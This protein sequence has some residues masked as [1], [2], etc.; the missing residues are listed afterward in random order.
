VDSRIERNVALGMDPESARREA[1]HRFGDVGAVRG[2]L[3]DHDA[4]RARAEDRRELLGD[5]M[6]DVRFGMRSLRRAPGFAVAAVLTLALGIGA[7]AAIF[8]VV[9]AIVLRPLPYERP[10]ELVSLGSGSAGE[11]LALR[12]RLR[13]ISPLA[14]YSTEM[15]PFDDGQSAQRLE[16]AAISTNLLP[17]LG[18]SP[19]LGRGF[20]DDEGRA[21]GAAVLVLSHGLWQR[22]FGGSEAAIGS[23]VRVDG[24]PH[25]IIGVMD[26]D[27]AFPSAATGFWTPYR[28]DTGNLPSTWAFGG[29]Q[30]VARLAP[31]AT[32][33]QAQRDL[34]VTWP[35]LRTENPMWDPG[36][37][38]R[39]DA[40][41]TPLGDEQAGDAAR[42]AWLLLGCVLLVL[43]IGCVNIANLLLARGT[44]RGP[45]LAVRTALGGGR[46][47]L[48]RQLVTESLLLSL[49]GSALGLVLAAAGVRWLVAALPA[50][51]PRVH[52]IGINGTVLAF[53]ASIAIA[54]GL[55][56]GIVPALRATRMA[57][58]AASQGGTRSTAG[59]GQHRL[60]GLLVV[61]EMALAVVLV[62]GASLLVRSFQAI[63]AVE[64]GF[65]TEQIVAARLTPPAGEY[66]DAARVS[67]LYAA[68]LERLGATP[69]VHA[70][71]AVD[72]LPIAQ[73]VYGMA[74]RVEGQ[75]EDLRR[76]LPGI[77]HV[78][79]VTPSYFTT[80][81]IPVLRGRG[82][83][84]ADREDQPPVVIVSESLAREFWPDDD[85]IGRRLGYPW[86]SPW[87]TIVGVVPDTRQ[88]SLL[89]PLAPTLYVPWRQ[90]PHTSGSEM[91]IVARS[92]L[93]ATAAAGAIRGIVREIDRAVPVSDMRTME[94][95]IANSLDRTRFTAVLVGTFAL[96]ALLLG[97]IGIYGVMSYLVSQR[98]QEL[99]VRLALGASQ[100][101]VLGFV[102]WR[103]IGLAA[104]GAVIGVAGA[105]VSTRW[106]RSLLYEVSATDAATFTLVP[107]LFLL[108]AAVATYAPARRA[109]AVDPVRALR[110]D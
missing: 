98:S 39:R 94:A 110:A 32:I 2:T 1:L 105:M 30:F 99:G 102:L 27:F 26:A 75:S 11:Y 15:H 48:V 95:V 70:V 62:I 97:S 52:E 92:S 79:Q 5:L 57:A 45:E 21:G 83:T 24:V 28:F 108:V 60:S 81:G 72:Q 107:L 20:V 109:T 36:P 63:R 53:T 74:A 93:G 76:A 29:R 4:R 23:R 47:R 38:Y 103:A 19:R 25:T 85:A 49:L 40:T 43:L 56:F 91:W 100:R 73:S 78:Q 14:L 86:P 88:D 65:R 55:L 64:P 9:E 3:V 7:N 77:S 6:Q 58:R 69:G 12:E 41:V 22:R 35:E 71:A 82:F 13:T 42:L 10:Q 68:V 51:V 67:A 89:A 96:A 33:A 44:A 90:R 59:V 31:G 34:S 8:S 80:L 54:S 46:G 50:S 66:Q 18:V 16:G 87:L 37:D 104:L 17:M 101:Q 61:G 84:D 106:L